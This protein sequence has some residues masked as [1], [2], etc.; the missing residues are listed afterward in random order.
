MK[1]IKGWFKEQAKKDS[2]QGSLETKENKK[3]IN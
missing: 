1:N 3:N 2:C